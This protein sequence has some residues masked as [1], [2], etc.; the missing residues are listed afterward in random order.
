MRQSEGLGM[1]QKDNRTIAFVC[2]GNTCRSPMAEAIFNDMAEKNGVCVRAE[3]FGIATSTGLPVSE[4]SVI[5]CKE[6]GIDLLGKASTAV[7]DAGIEKYEKFYCM[8][9]SHAKMLM[10][11][12][13]V[14]PEKIAVLGISDPYGGDIEVYRHC[15]DEIVNSV[16]EI[17]KAYEN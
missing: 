11:F 15:R 2:T 12:F 10:Q 17:L 7:A 16:K 9:Q 13:L 8:S 6:I 3:S 5:A 14:Q 1:M 4:N